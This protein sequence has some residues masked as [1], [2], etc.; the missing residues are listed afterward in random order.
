MSSR[1]YRVKFPHTD[2][3]AVHNDLASAVADWA[4]QRAKGAWIEVTET[5]RLVGHEELTDA[6]AASLASR[7]AAGAGHNPSAGR[8]EALAMPRL[9]EYKPEVFACNQK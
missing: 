2:S 6:G 9:G 7:V 8:L 4:E 5:R 1:I 3:L